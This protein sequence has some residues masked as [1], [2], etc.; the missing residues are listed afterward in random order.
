MSTMNTQEIMKLIEAGRSE[1]EIAEYISKTDYE[2]ASE[3]YPNLAAEIP[4]R[5]L[6]SQLIARGYFVLPSRASEKF[7]SLSEEEQTLIFTLMNRMEDGREFTASRRIDA[8]SESKIK[9]RLGNVFPDL[10]N[11]GG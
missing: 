10:F 7:E 8:E 2:K 4:D 9:K 1:S 11:A 6:V 3:Q 5:I